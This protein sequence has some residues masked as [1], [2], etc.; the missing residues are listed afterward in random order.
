ML[1]YRLLANHRDCFIGRKIMTVICE[2][3]QIQRWNQPIG[4]IPSSHIDL[5]ILQCGGKQTQIHDP[6]RRGEAQAISRGQPGISVGTLHELV[7]K[8][9]TPLRSERS[10]LGESFEIQ[11]TRI[12]PANFQCKRVVEAEWRTERKV[13]TLFVFAFDPLVDLG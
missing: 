11:A 5:M 1:P 9:S 6:R 4:S 12:G 8:S 13:K 2:H 10:R 7:A 3:K